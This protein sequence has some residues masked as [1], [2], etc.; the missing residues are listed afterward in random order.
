MQSSAIEM[1][2][3][4][5]YYEYIECSHY[6]RRIIYRDL[7]VLHRL[8]TDN[9]LYAEDSTDY[10]KILRARVHLKW[11]TGHIV[12][13][14]LSGLLQGN[15]PK[16]IDQLFEL[17]YLFLES[18]RLDSIPSILGELPQLYHLYLDDNPIQCNVS[19]YVDTALSEGKYQSLYL[20]SSDHSLIYIQNE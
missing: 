11:D 19:Q 10:H 7:L 2:V 5:F 1:E 20:L 17:K 9:I 8:Y 18:C 4:D 14:N 6:Y 15:I 3:E 16:Y 13:L 12:Y